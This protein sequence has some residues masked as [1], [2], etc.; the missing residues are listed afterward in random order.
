M[1]AGSQVLFTNT[2]AGVSNTVV[3]NFPGGTPAT[4]NSVGPHIVTFPTPGT[5]MVSLSVNGGPSSTLQVVISVSNPSITPNLMLNNGCGSNF[6]P[7]IYNNVSYFTSCSVGAFTGDYLCFNTNST[8][9]NA[10]SIHSIDWGNGTGSTFQGINNSNPGFSAAVP[11]SGYSYVTYTLQENPNSCMVSKIYP[12][13]AGSI[14]SANISV[15]GV[16]SNCYPWGG[17]QYAL[18]PGGQN[19]MGTSYSLTVND[20]SVPVLFN[21]PP[22][23]NYSHTFNASSCGIQSV[24]NGISYPNSFQTVLTTSNA[25]GS[26]TSTVGPINV[27]SAPQSNFSSTPVLNPSYDSICVGDSVLFTDTTI[28]GNNIQAGTFQCNNSYNRIWTISGPNGAITGSNANLIINGSLGSANNILNTGTWNNGSASLSLTFLSPGL[29]TLTLFVGGPSYNPCGIDTMVYHINVINCPNPNLLSVSASPI[30][31]TICSGSSTIPV[32]WISNQPNTI[33]TWNLTSGNASIQGALISGNG[34]IPSM[35][36]VNPSNTPQTITYTATSTFNALTTTCIH[37]I[38]VN[39]TPIV[40]PVFNQVVCNGTNTAAISFSGTATSYSWNN[41]NATIGVTNAGVGNIPSFVAINNSMSSPNQATFTVSPLYPNN[42]VTCVGNT[43]SYTITVLPTALVNNVMNQVV[44]NGVLTSPINFSGTAM[45]YNWTNSNP[46]I[47]ISGSG[48]GNIPSFTALNNNIV[49]VTA[50]FVVIPIYSMMGISCP[51]SP[52]QFTIAVVPTPSLQ[53]NV[54]NQTVCSPGQ[55]SPVSALSATPGASMSWVAMPNPNVTGVTPSS[56]NNTI[57]SFFLT[58]L[59]VSPQTV[60]I[61]VVPSA[62]L[63]GLTCTGNNTQYLITVNPSISVYAGQDQPICNGLTVTL[64]GT[65][66]VSYIWDNNIQD[67]IPFIPTTTQTY[68]VIGTDGNGCSASDQV[69]VTV[70]NQ[71]NLVLN[72]V[73]CSNFTLNGQIYNQSGTYYQ[74]LTNAVGCDS[75]ITINLTL[76]QLPEIPNIN[77]SGNGELSIPSQNNSTYQW[78]SCSTGASLPNGTDTL[79]IPINN[80]LFAV[81]VTNDCGTVTSECITINNIGLGEM[82]HNVYIGPNPTNDFAFIFGLTDTPVSYSLFDVLGRTIQEGEFS[83]NKNFL[84]LSALDCGNYR[85]IVD[86]K[87]VFNLVKRQ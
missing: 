7:S 76:N 69:T 41:N 64:Q 61:D 78:I 71:S 15:I 1:C 82:S 35:V 33:T 9:T 32:N 34:S 40:N 59:G 46:M 84:N 44:C 70:L 2:T 80:G 8:G 85:V 43:Q 66:A 63:N 86:R 79:F 58:N 11:T 49:P 26:S 16:P 36:L 48:Y 13:Y 24:I 29:Y 22:P 68:T 6:G 20:G 17:N 18:S 23:V 65:G 39:P 62:T 3:W 87:W 25:C 56:G 81:E 47:G 75:I 5:Y 53:F 74:T 14:P 60:V 77:V 28:P 4:S 54:A 42:N 21:H 50:V 55:S 52:M 31:Q 37:S 51:G 10:S 73:T 67:G 38:T 83:I 30:N 12:I 72:E 57:P 45:S 27:Q 19:S